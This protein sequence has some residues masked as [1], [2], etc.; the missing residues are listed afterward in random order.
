M[1]TKSHKRSRDVLYPRA[2]HS[3]AT[4]EVKARVMARRI[5]DR[6]RKGERTRDDLVDWALTQ[7]GDVKPMSA[8]EAAHCLQRQSDLHEAMDDMGEWGALNPAPSRAHA[9]IAGEAA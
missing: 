7:T 1:N 6:V 3:T 4:D 2:F 9:R 8:E 5:L